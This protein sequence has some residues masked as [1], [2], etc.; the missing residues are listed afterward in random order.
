MIAGLLFAREVDL[1]GG[2]LGVDFVADEGV[3]PGQQAACGDQGD[4][5]EQAGDGHQDVEG[6]AFHSVLPR[7]ERLASGRVPARA[8]L[9]G[10]GR[11]ASGA[12]GPVRAG[13]ARAAPVRAGSVGGDGRGAAGRR[14]Y[15]RDCG[16]GRGGGVLLAGEEGAG[17]GD[18]GHQRGGE[19]HGGVLVHADLDQALQVAQLQG[20]R[21]G[22]H[23]VGRLAQRGGGQRFAF[24][25][26]DLRALFPSRFGLLGH[27]AFH[28]V[29]ELDV[30]QLDQG[31]L[32]APRDGGDVEDLADVQVD[33]VGLRQG[34]VEGVLAT[35]LR[36]VVWAIWLIAEFTSSMATTDLTASVTR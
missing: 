32:H 6:S 27:R 16:R 21:V 31:D 19:D 14:Q 2:E 22:H 13:A 8:R 11:A 35:T 28:G 9:T 25:V 17:F 20:Q 33:L 1:L 15:R 34:L 36:R 30:L 4:G 12:G 18:G 24:G 3:G 7:R 26:D 23:R 5:Q 29:R 10:T